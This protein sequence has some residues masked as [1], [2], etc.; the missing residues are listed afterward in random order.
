MDA[1]SIKLALE[2]R[3]IPFVTH[4]RVPPN[5]IT[6]CALA[7]TL[8][9]AGLVLAES[10]VVA[11]VLILIAGILDILD[12]AVARATNTATAFGALL[13]RVSD[14]IG[15]FAVLGSLI[16]AGYTEITL[17]LYTLLTVMLASYIS[18]CIEAAT[19]SRV[20]EKLSLRAVRIALIVLACFAMRINEAMVILAVVGTYSSVTR[21][22]Q[23]WRL[24]DAGAQA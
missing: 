3:I 18:A 9:A 15:D 13:D 14:R 12:G 22:A 19:H 24:L 7:F 11:G 10:L 4:V 17:G 20:G 6:L 8:A 2:K 23:A 5:V 1:M 16:A 21:M